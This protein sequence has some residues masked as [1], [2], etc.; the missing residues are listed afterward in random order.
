MGRRDGDA[1]VFP[2]LLGDIDCN[3][4]SSLQRG[5]RLALYHFQEL[6]GHLLSWQ[7]GEG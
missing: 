7:V 6:W 5:Q 2:C 4:V 3:H 1:G